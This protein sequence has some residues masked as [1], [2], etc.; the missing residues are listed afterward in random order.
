MEDAGTSDEDDI[1]SQDSNTPIDHGHLALN[2]LIKITMPAVKASVI[3]CS[4][5]IPHRLIMEE[6]GARVDWCKKLEKFNAGCSKNIF[7]IMTG[8][9]S[10]IYQLDPE[11]KRQF[12][13]RNFPGENPPTKVKRSRSVGK[14]MM[15][16]LFRTNGL[17]ATVPLEDQRTVTADWYVTKCLPKVF[18]ALRRE[19]QKT[20]L[21]GILL[22]HN[23]AS[24]HHAHKTA[25]F[26]VESGVQTSSHP[27]YSVDLAPCDFF[28]FFRKRRIKFAVANL[29]PLKLQRQHMKSFLATCLKMN[30]E[31][32]IQNG[33]RG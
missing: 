8:D 30:G 29:S 12:S 2:C 24:A 27:T 5:C 6:K 31:Q 16:S 23:N 18:D 11:T 32:H 33:L 28:F 9:E 26:L 22:Y 20:G 15:F 4:H 3:S 14:K 25:T 19:R 13:V 1:D 17:I 10:S 21:H 7:N